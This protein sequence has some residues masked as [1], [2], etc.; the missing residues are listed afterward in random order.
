MLCLRDV[1]ASNSLHSCSIPID[2]QTRGTTITEPMKTLTRSELGAV[3]ILLGEFW[4]RELTLARVQQLCATE[5][6]DALSAFEWSLPQAT[7]DD[8]Q[9]HLERLQID[10]CQLLIGPK[11][12]ISPVESVWAADQFQSKSVDQMKSFFDLLPGYQ[13]PDRFHDHIGVQLDFAGHLLIAADQHASA[14]TEQADDLLETYVQQRIVW[15]K[16]MLAKVHRQ[17]QTSF[18]R[19]L[20]T[21]T[22]QWISFFES[23]PSS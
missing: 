23:K 7:D 9:E 12:H 10:Y 2:T 11:G 20:S 14:E 21:V 15:A 17:A 3:A 18:Y 16:P 22:Q 8:L 4:L 6:T 5:I 13:P 1:R 19:R